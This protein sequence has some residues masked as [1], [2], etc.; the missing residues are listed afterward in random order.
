[1]DGFLSGYVVVGVSYTKIVRHLQDSTLRTA[2]EV[3]VK[4][5]ENALGRMPEVL[6]M[7][8]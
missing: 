7:A 2:S 3:M 8:A 6:P 1:M 5:L 4:M